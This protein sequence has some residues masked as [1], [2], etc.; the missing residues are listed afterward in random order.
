LTGLFGPRG[1]ADELRERIAA[2]VIAAAADPVIPA[3]LASIGQIMQLHGAA[4][5]AARIDEQRA[6]LAAIA[7]SLGRKPAQ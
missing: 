5:F 4:D 1:M 2:D 6:T 7:K 3:R